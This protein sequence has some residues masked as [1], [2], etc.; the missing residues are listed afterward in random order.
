MLGGNKEREIREESISKWEKER[1]KYYR[2]RRV[3]RMDEE[4]AQMLI[5]KEKERQR[6]ERWERIKS[7]KYNK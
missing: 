1:M 7:S 3:K 4:I 6:E 2:D 5:S